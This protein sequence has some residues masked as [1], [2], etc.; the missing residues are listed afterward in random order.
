VLVRR[1]GIVFEAVLRDL[2]RQGCQVAFIKV[3]SHV[4]HG[5]A[6][7]GIAIP[8]Q[9]AVPAAATAVGIA[10]IGYRIIGTASVP[11]PICK[12]ERKIL[13]AGATIG[14]VQDWRA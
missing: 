9:A 3:H 10:Y 1:R 6:D 7:A 11:A 12:G 8:I 2:V 5:I 4:R 14:L 13:L